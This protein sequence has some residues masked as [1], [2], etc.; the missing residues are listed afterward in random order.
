VAHDLET[1]LL[2]GVRVPEGYALVPIKPTYDMLAAGTHHDTTDENS[3]I[4]ADVGGIWNAMVLVALAASQG[5]RDRKD[6]G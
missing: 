6:E 1:L 4:G 3:D 5:E 2:S